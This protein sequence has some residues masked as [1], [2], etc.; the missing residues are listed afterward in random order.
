MTARVSVVGSANLDIVLRVGRRPSAGE[1]VMSHAVSETPG[2][3]GANQALSSARIAPTTL[4]ASIGRDSAGRSV[5]AALRSGSVD[6]E[7]LSR[8][9]TPTGL[10]YVTLTPDGEN[11]IVVV[12]LANSQLSPELV[13][14]ALD[15]SH[16]TIVLLQL[17]VP[18]AVTAAV[19]AWCRRHNARLVF[20]PSPMD[21]QVVA[22]ATD[23][24]PLILNAH[25][26]A[27]LTQADEPDI[28]TL[29]AS[30]SKTY[31]SVL[32]TAGSAGAFVG[33][34]GRV[35]HIQGAPVSSVVDT[36]GAGD[37]FAGT[38]A[39]HL[40]LGVDLVE[41]AALANAEAGRTIQLERAHR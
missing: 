34:D 38:L 7:Y 40:A 21:A 16:P 13:L 23:A 30:L 28:E 8:V 25:E 35:I 17:E 1:T 32:V 29:V 2:G 12:G 5:E 39:A 9:D 41:A 10:A 19:L 37:A 20:N 11:S 22:R 6:L 24:D 27:E 4:I 15:R 31:R 26:V 33:R 3:K 14:V 36:T 18:R